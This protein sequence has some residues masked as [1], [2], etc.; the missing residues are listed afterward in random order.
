MQQGS[1]VLIRLVPASGVLLAVGLK[2]C[3]NV[4][5]KFNIFLSLL[6]KFAQILTSE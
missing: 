4:L 6:D 2:R 5:N 3:D 1:P